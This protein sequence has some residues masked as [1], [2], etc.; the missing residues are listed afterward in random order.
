MNDDDGND[1]DDSNDDDNDDVSRHI[2]I[3]VRTDRRCSIGSS[4][5]RIV[6]NNST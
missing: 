4:S 3:D 5:V 6:V 2:L 1:N